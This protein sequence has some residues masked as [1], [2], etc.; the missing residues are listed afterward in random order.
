MVAPQ[1]GRALYELALPPKRFV[2]VQGA[3]HENTHVLGEQQYRDALH[4]LFGLGKP[5]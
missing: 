1:L 4:E 3:V 2:L 5:R